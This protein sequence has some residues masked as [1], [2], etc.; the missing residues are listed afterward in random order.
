MEP[1]RTARFAA[2]EIPEA[3]QREHTL[4]AGVHV[5]L[6]VL[7][8]DLTFVDA[9]GGRHPLAAGNERHVDSRPHHLEDVEG[10]A[11]EIKFFKN[12]P[13]EED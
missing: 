2:G 4:K 3:L 13:S 8:G 1:Y 10:A 9:D 5:V 11:I 7:Q 6:T 12:A